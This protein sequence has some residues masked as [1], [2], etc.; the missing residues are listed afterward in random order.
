[1][2]FSSNFGANGQV[3]AF[4]D[5]NTLWLGYGYGTLFRSSTRGCTW[6]IYDGPSPQYGFK[7]MAVSPETPTG[8]VFLAVE[9]YYDPTDLNQYYRLVRSTAPPLGWATVWDKSPLFNQI[10]FSP[11]FAA[12]GTVFVVCT[13]PMP[14]A[15][16]I[17]ATPG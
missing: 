13:R 9:A 8:P 5:H 3:Y 10:V 11:A 4:S 12:D 6:E 1:M 2:Q 17:A 16:R 14:I 7:L 15:P